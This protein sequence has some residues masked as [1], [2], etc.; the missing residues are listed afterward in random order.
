MNGVSDFHVY[1]KKFIKIIHIEKNRIIYLKPLVK[2][3][4]K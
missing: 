2:H 1:K 3:K 4:L